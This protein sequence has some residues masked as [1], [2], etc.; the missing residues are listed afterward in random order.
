[1][2]LKHSFRRVR[3]TVLS[4]ACAAA[5]VSASAYP[6]AS[7]DVGQGR[8]IEFGRPGDIFQVNRTVEISLR[9]NYFTPDEVYVQ[10]GETIRFVLK[11]DGVLL[12]EFNIGTASMHVRH[13]AEMLMFRQHGMLNQK[14]VNRTQIE[15]YSGKGD[16]MS[17]NDPTSEL[18][19]PGTSTELVWKFTKAMVLQ[20]ACNI[21]GHYESGMLGAFVFSEKP[22]Q[23][24]S[25]E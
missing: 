16:S 7:H 25:V 24:S 17:H 4:T 3:A 14:S 21:P 22:E 2:I 10:P 15:N 12:H 8:R 20:F 11:N 1:M 5:L 9:D 6:T 18:H 23:V 13:Q 19:D